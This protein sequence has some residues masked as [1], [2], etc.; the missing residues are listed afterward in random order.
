MAQLV[1]DQSGRSA[2]RQPSPFRL[3][4]RFVRLRRFVLWCFLL[5]ILVVASTA[6]WL[7][8]Q[9]R[10][11]LSKISDAPSERQGSGF[12]PFLSDRTAETLQ[13]ENDN[14]I[15]ILLLGMGGA[16]HPGGLLTDT[17]MVLG[18]APEEGRLGLVSLPRDLYVPIKG[19]G[20]GKLNSAHALG[21]QTKSGDGPTLARD[22]IGQI[23]A[24]PIPYYVRLDFAGFVKLV[25]AVG[26]VDITVEKAISDPFFPDEKLEGYEPFYLKAGLTHMDGDVA[27]KYARSRETTSDFDRSRRQQQL[28]S[29]LKD[30]ILSLGTLTNPKKVLELLEIAGSHIRTNLAVWEIE[31]LIA[32]AKNVD[33]DAV[34]TK[35]LDTRADGPLTSRT[36][37]RAGYIIVPRTGN[38]SELQRLAK[39]LF[40]SGESTTAT[41]TLENGSGRADLGGNLALLLRG[42]G[43]E[44][45]DVT[46]RQTPVKKSRLLVKEAGKYPDID[47][48]FLDRF[49]VKPEVASDASVA[50]VLF[51]I[52]QD[53]AETQP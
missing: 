22:T 50:D 11:A 26:G 29:A 42:Y 12:L 17:I 6:G 21:E 31:R 38:F 51:I 5:A 48:F 8:W 32:L 36:D 53:Y 27:L 13:G 52:G 37:E 25:D 34:V 14:R 45:R 16:G 41:I 24:L 10:A 18:Y 1:W 46:N 49:Q 15:N 39:N 9:A 7:G 43:Y 3:G 20:S 19:H 47:R 35:V 2:A 30:K 40:S 28:L 33:P 44:V 23:L 4:G